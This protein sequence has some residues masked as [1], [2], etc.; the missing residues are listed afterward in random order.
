MYVTWQGLIKIQND[1]RDGGQVMYA[2]STGFLKKNSQRLSASLLPQWLFQLSFAFSLVWKTYL[3]SLQHKFL[4]PSFIKKLHSFQSRRHPFIPACFFWWTPLP[5][6]HM[7]GW[8]E[9]IGEKK[10]MLILGHVF[11]L[12]LYW[13]KACS[14]LHLPLAFATQ[15]TAERNGNITHFTWIHQYVYLKR[16]MVILIFQHSVL[17]RQ[18]QYLNLIC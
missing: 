17:L 8:L 18:T 11:V 2:A 5:D 13:P 16:Q 14:F 15:V 12:H 9:G 3:I 1:D 7:T 10:N 6:W 4:H